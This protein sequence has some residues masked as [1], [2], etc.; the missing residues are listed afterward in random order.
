MTIESP[1]TYGEYYWST[2]TDAVK[3]LD[4]QLED[5]YSPYF[6]GILADIPDISVLPHGIQTL[7]LAMANPEHAGMGGFALGVGVETVDETLHT[8]M[9][10]IMA[11]LTRAINIRSR[12]KWLTSAEANLLWSRNKIQEGLWS[13]ILASEGY[14]DVLGGMLYKSQIPYPSIPDLITYSRYNGDPNDVWGTL[15]EFYRIDANDFKLW[16]WL[17]Q[18]KLTLEQAHTLYRRKK[19]SEYDLSDMLAR[20]GWDRYDREHQQ[21]LG[22]QIPN[23]MLLV[24]GGLIEGK[25]DEELL[26]DIQLGDIHPDF[27]QRYLDAVLAKPATTDIVAYELRKDPNL[28]NLAQELRKIGIHPDYFEL[29]KELGNVIPPVGDIITMAVREAFTP[30]IAERFGQYE[31]FPSALEFW[32]GKKGLSKEWAERYWAAHWSLPSPQQGFEM[33]HRGVIDKNDL[34]MLLR[35]LDIMPFWRDKLTS[36]AY[37]VITRVDIRRMYATGVLSEADVEQSYLEAGYNDRDAKRLTK[38]TV[39]STQQT[40]SKFNSGDIIAAYADRKIDRAEANRL[41][42]NLGIRRE[43]IPHILESAEYKKKWDYID[44]QTKAIKN[45]YKKKALDK[46]ETRNKLQQLGVH[47]EEIESLMNQWF[48]EIPEE[49]PKLWSQAQ[50]LA[51]LKK[52]IITQD[53]ARQELDLLG[54]DAEHINV[55]VQSTAKTTK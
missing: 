40:L 14:E 42:E 18:Q 23:A 49:E 53:R 33:L 34:N 9:Q 4:E 39:V 28:T 27:T 15:Q 6:R 50:V 55:Y 22:W 43:D 32:A 1:Q 48:Y 25:S 17:S 11:M 24:Q 16:E 8:A 47:S 35:A 26:N 20:M 41:L 36:I 7:L 54:Y 38:F 2:H 12:E 19:I 51:F 29:Y 5:L 46:D 37:N 31:D 45:L 10:P 52:G 13:S 30:Y 21:E 44:L 3:Y